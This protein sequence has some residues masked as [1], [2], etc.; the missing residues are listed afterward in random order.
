MENKSF[1]WLLVG[2]QT[3]GEKDKSL[4]VKAGRGAARAGL[5]LIG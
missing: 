3:D 1:I 4:L 5:T 2:K